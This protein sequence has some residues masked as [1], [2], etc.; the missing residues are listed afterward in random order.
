[1]QGR[2]TAPSNPV[3][4]DIAL[5]NLILFLGVHVDSSL[6][7]N[8]YPQAFAASKVTIWRF[9]QSLDWKDDSW[10]SDRGCGGEGV[11]SEQVNYF[12]SNAD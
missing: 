11:G 1:M 4:A 7:A 9:T 2:I 10:G 5:S 8:V 3:P 6:I 12:K